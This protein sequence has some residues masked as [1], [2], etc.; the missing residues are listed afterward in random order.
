[1]ATVGVVGLVVA[2]VATVGVV[3]LVVT[4][5]VG[6]PSVGFGSVLGAFFSHK[7]RRGTS[8]IWVLTWSSS[9]S[10]YDIKIGR[11][12]YTRLYEG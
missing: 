9:Q 2:A 12:L 11:L 1:M 3:G 10:V 7:K 4:A 5:S 8:L 6:A